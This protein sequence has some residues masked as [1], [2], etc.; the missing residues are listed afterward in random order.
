MLDSSLEEWLGAAHA[1]APR[2]RVEHVQEALK[3]A[4]IKRVEQAG[5]HF[6]E[7]P[8]KERERAIEESKKRSAHHYPELFPSSLEGRWPVECPA[9]SSQAFLAGIS[10][11]E[12][13]VE[14]DPET[15][16]E[17]VEKYYSAERLQC[18]VCELHLDSR[19]EIEAVGLD[20][21]HTE[22]EEREREYEPDYGNC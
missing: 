3:Q 10:Y 21:D 1:R 5:E 2:E 22:I 4:A 18:P 19:E 13:V 15:D 8:K 17:E 6:N 16:F 11:D 9:C 20:P 7:R 12:E 14:P